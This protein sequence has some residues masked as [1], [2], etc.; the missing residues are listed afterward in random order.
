M[1]LGRLGFHDQL[2]DCVRILGAQPAVQ[3]M[4]PV[5]VDLQQVEA[6]KLLVRVQAAVDAGQILAGPRVVCLGE[7]LDGAAIAGVH[8]G[9]H[10]LQP[11]SRR[12]RAGRGLGPAG[13]HATAGTG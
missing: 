3:L 6:A 5:V 10:L 9:Q 2:Q 11:G 1:R 7:C 13:V 12:R 8:G 4:R